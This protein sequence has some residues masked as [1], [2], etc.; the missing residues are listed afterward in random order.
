MSLLSEQ[1]KEEVISGVINGFRDAGHVHR[2]FRDFTQGVTLR[3]LA[4]SRVF[5]DILQ[6]VLDQQ[7]IEK[8]SVRDLIL[9][10]SNVTFSRAFDQE[11]TRKTAQTRVEGNLMASITAMSVERYL[12]NGRFFTKGEKANDLMRLSDRTRWELKGARAKNFTL[13]INQSHQDIDHTYFLVYNG[14]PET[15]TIHGI[16]AVTGEDQ[17]FSPRRPGLNLRTFKKE[18]IETHVE[19]ILKETRLPE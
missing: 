19:C 2:Q 6:K 16:Y 10:F 3:A 7:E 18:F 13:T 4:P 12:Q 14:F 9:K 15:R 5:L 17:C 1:E 11:W 8:L